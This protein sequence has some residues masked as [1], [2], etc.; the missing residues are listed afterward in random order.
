MPLPSAAQRGVGG[1][2]IEFGSDDVRIA[3]IAV[4]DVEVGGLVALVA[5]IEAGVGDE[6]AVG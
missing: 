3:A 6:F 5:V 2:A 1:V 4:G